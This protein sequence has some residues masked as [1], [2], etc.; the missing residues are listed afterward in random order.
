MAKVKT[1]KDLEKCFKNSGVYVQRFDSQGRALID[2]NTS[3]NEF[4]IVK[5]LE[6]SL[7]PFYEKQ[8][9]KVLT[10][11]DRE[12]YQ[13]RLFRELERNH[14]NVEEPYHFEN[15]GNSLIWYKE[16]EWSGTRVIAELDRFGC[17]LIECENDS[18]AQCG[19]HRDITL[20]RNGKKYN[21]S[22]IA[23]SYS[24]FVFDREVYLIEY[25]DLVDRTLRVL[26][27][28]DDYKK[29]SPSVVC[30]HKFNERIDRRSMNFKTLRCVGASIL[31][32]HKLTGLYKK[33]ALDN[34]FAN[35]TA[36]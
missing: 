9:S 4:N 13:D 21:L 6:K 34:L 7:V 2:S 5:F 27:V 36:N 18:P 33:S 23:D 1:F 28:E 29:S 31:F 22:N 35:A 24:Y 12:D 3:K 15:D 30:E 16:D 26:K 19:G 20:Y 17:L 32:T 14:I 25:D 8:T 10:G 11:Q